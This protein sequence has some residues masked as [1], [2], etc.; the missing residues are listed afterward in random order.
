MK[1]AI[2]FA[3][4]RTLFFLLFTI[5]L[6]FQAKSINAQRL[7]LRND[8]FNLIMQLDLT[9]QDIIVPDHELYGPVA[10][11][12]GKTNHSFYWIAVKV[13]NT[14]KGA[15]IELI[16]DFGSEN[17]TAKIVQLNDSTYELTQ[18]KGSTLRLPEGGKWQ[19]MPTSLIFRSC[20]RSPEKSTP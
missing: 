19:K 11:F 4:Y 3:R 13:E 10:G 18:L 1:K 5:A 7:D 17:L 9:N 15:T 6:S 14:K 2:F 12:V 20:K 8:K 16:N